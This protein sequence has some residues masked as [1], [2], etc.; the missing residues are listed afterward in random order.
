MKVIKKIKN[1]GFD[2]KG[3]S[4]DQIKK[5]E[6][7]YDIELPNDYKLFLKEMG[8][9]AGEFLIGED[10]FYDRIFELREYAEDLLIEDETDFRLKPEHF[11]FFSH[12]GYIFSFFDTSQT[13]PKIYYYHEGD[14]E[15]TIKYNSLECFLE[16]YLKEVSV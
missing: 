4:L 2:L 7:F 15:P 3:I 14:M 13:N 6:N 9:S 11:V 5:I 8:Y 1:R 12:Q 10:C 16:N